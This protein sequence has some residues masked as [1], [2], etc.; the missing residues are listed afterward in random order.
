M[1]YISFNF[2]YS[3]RR[4]PARQIAG[5]K[6]TKSIDNYDVI[7]NDNQIPFL[8]K[9]HIFFSQDPLDIQ[10]INPEASGYLC[11]LVSASWRIA[12]RH[13]PF[14]AQRLSV[15]RNGSIDGLLPVP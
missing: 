11:A 14:G 12:Q 10:L 8:K 9:T 2:N 6:D 4:L 13:F 15:R 3:P 5:G 7:N 1:F